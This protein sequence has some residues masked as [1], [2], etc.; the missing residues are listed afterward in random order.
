MQNK[1]RWFSVIVPVYNV[2][3]Y[4]R[5]CLESIVN[6]DFKDFELIIIDDGSCDGS[7]LMCDEYG[8]KYDFCR[9][10]HQENGGLSSARNAGLNYAT[11]KY[12]LFV[13]SDDYIETNTL[14]KFYEVTKQSNVDMVAAYG[15][16]VLHDNKI[17]DRGAFRTGFDEIVSGKEYY[18]RTLYEGSYSAASVY[19]LTK[20]SV[21]RD[22]GLQFTAGL[23][24]EDELWT[25][26]LMVCC[27]SIVDLKFR[28]YY[29][30]MTNSSSITRN[31]D[32]AKKRA[33]SRIALSKALVEY[34]NKVKECHIRA[35]LDNASAQYMYGVYIGGLLKDSTFKVDRS[36]PI[37]NS[38]SLKY[39]AKALLFFI[40]PRLA[41]VMRGMKDVMPH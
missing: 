11:G 27:D 6:Q 38:K 18:S 20:L 21:I 19:N 5:S 16:K 41:C 23:L 25:P 40:S 26:R 14:R 24:H 1:I 22:N 35:F 33:M 7:S 34:Y 10:I 17:E 30:R 31:P 8:S 12:V 29:Y 9:V 15:Y 4:L 28:F 13:D 37:R 2:E 3:Q 36:F 39:K 32:A